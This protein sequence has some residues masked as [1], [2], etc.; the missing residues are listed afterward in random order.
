MPVKEMQETGSIP[1]S[2][3]SPGVGNGKPLQY[4]SLENLMDRRAWGF[5][6]WGRKVLDTTEHTHS[7]AQLPPFKT[8]N[9]Q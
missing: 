7:A 1:G 4:C 6:L 8:Y 3:R 5:S 9:T 2:E